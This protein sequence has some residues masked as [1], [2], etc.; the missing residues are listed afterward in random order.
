[1]FVLTRECWRGGSGCPWTEDQGGQR[2]QRCTGTPHTEDGRGSNGAKP[3]CLRLPRGCRRS[4]W[5]SVRRWVNQEHR[6]VLMRVSSLKPSWEAPRYSII[7]TASLQ[8]GEP[9]SSPPADW[10]LKRGPA[11][12]CGAATGKEFSLVKMFLR[13]L[14]YAPG[15]V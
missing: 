2:R 4:P 10:V 5:L 3:L 14:T 15:S 12:L 13:D 7:D 11:N 6:P 9:G 1:M 8:E